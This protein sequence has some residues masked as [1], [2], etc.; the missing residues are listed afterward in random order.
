MST[1]LRPVVEIAELATKR[2][3]RKGI[4]VSAVEMGNQSRI[5]PSKARSEKP[6][7]IDCPGDSA[8]RRRLERLTIVELVKVSVYL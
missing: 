6:V 5:A 8:S 4:L 2:A 1:T 3:S 7:R